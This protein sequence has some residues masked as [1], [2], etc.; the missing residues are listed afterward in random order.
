[1]TTSGDPVPADMYAD[2]A[3]IVLRASREISFQGYPDSEA[4]ALA[5]SNANVMR[6]IDSHPGATPSEVAHAT[7]L[8]RSNLSAALKELERIGFID[9]RVDPLDGRGVRLYSTP[10]AARNLRIIRREW[11]R[12]VAAALGDSAD[13]RSGVA[14]LERLT[15]GLVAS[16]QR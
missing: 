14:L 4:I 10:A 13:V 7:G 12:Q 9:R 6:H 3:E 5:P 11:A 1:M 2:L 16:R 8:L 15:A